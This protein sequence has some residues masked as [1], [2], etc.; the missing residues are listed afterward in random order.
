M[1]DGS[2]ARTWAETDSNNC[3]ARGVKEQILSKSCR[4]TPGTIFLLVIPCAIEVRKIDCY[5][6]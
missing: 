2:G 5:Q 6:H 1:D 3:R 4:V